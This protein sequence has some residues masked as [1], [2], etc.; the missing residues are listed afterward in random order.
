MK[1][2]NV[3]SKGEITEKARKLFKEERAKKRLDGWFLARELAF[4]ATGFEIGRAHV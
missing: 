3:Y 1:A 2:T 4:K